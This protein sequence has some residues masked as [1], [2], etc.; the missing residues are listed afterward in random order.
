MGSTNTSNSARIARNSVAE[1]TIKRE[2]HFVIEEL[3][4]H[5]KTMFVVQ[6]IAGVFLW[7]NFRTK[8]TISNSPCHSSKFYQKVHSKNFRLILHAPRVIDAGGEIYFVA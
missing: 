5:M 6:V 3:A 8:K 2:T 1:E 4:T 7:F